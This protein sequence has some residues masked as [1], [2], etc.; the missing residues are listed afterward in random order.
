MLQGSPNLLTV[1]LVHCRL[2]L[3]FLSFFA[4]KGGEWILRHVVAFALEYVCILLGQKVREALEE[5]A[6]V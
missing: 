3:P 1:V 6:E 4:C 2:P 5:A